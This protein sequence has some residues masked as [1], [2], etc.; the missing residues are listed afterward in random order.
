VSRVEIFEH[1][2][3]TL[4]ADTTL[5]VLLG[6][7]SPTNPRIL[8]AYSQLQELLT[9]P[10]GYEPSGGEGWL[11]LLEDESQPKAYTE[12]EETIYEVVDFNFTV[13]S[14]RYSIA[15]DVCD[16]LDQ[17]WHW[18]AEQQR[19]VQYGDYILL[20]TRRLN[21]YEGYAQEIKMYQKTHWYR[22]TFVLETQ[23]A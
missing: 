12:Q 4:R 11:V 14:T 8:R 17:T 3:S 5:P 10:P 13:F 21:T 9:L 2:Y 15:D 7:E 16:V 1:I 18:T 6:A 19:D 20:M 23:V 22:M